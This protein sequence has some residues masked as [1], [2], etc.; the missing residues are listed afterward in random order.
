MRTLAFFGC[1]S[2]SLVYLLGMMNFTTNLPQAQKRVFGTV[3]R[4][5]VQS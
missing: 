4:T 2:V 3:H 5:K 1:G